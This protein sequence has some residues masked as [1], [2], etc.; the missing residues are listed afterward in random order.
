MAL[1]AATTFGHSTIETTHLLLGAVGAASGA[2][3]TALT[4]GDLRLEDLRRVCAGTACAAT[5]PGTPVPPRNTVAPVAGVA[6][7]SIAEFERQLD[8]FASVA[9]KVREAHAAQVL[10][11]LLDRCAQARAALRAPS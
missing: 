3:Q 1:E 4:S 7:A 2:L 6:A 8:T 5:E 11:E 10:R 9:E